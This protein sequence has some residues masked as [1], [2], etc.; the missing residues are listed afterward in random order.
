MVY[1]YGEIPEDV[2]FKPYMPL[3]NNTWRIYQTFGWEVFHQFNLDS[4][5]GCYDF[6]ETRFNESIRTSEDVI[7]GKLKAPEKILSYIL[8]LP[9]VAIRAD[10]LQGAS[11]LF[12]GE[13]V[14]LTYIILKHDTQEV[15]ALLNGHLENGLPVDWWFIQPD[16]ELLDRRHMKIG[17]K[18]KEIP[19]RIKDLRK[20]SLRLIDVFKDIRNERTPQ[21]ANAGYNVIN[22]YETFALNL[23][24]EPSSFEN[25]AQG[26]DGWAAKALY[27]LPD[28]AFAL[29]PWPSMLN[30]FMYQGRSEFSKKVAGLA[31]EGHLYISPFEEKN[32]ESIKSRLPH[33][34]EWYQTEKIAKG[35]PYPVQTLNCEFPN[36]KNK[37][38]PDH[39]FD[40]KY[41]PGEWIQSKNLGLTEE[42]LLEGVFLNVT[43]ETPVEEKIDQAHIVSTGVGRTTKFI[44]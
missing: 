36:V 44:K 16:D 26:Y 14:D 32:R 19:Q 1:S 18:L 39:R 8:I 31:T 37:K 4:Q 13:S 22:A 40:P 25:I 5:K 43:H 15:F 38:D 17:Y 2:R 12:A 34:W 24:Y 3:Y 41:P 27:G 7:G 6:F 35:V 28:F 29:I 10:L 9:N 33:I 21:W 42:E 20:S 23:L 11:K 30:A